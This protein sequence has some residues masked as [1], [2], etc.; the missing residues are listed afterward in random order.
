MAFSPFASQELGGDPHNHQLEREGQKWGGA[1]ELGCHVVG[2]CP[3]K[4]YHDY[5]PAIQSIEC[6][7]LLEGLS[8]VWLLRYERKKIILAVAKFLSALAALR[9][10]VQN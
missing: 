3:C 10:V 8:S 6:F 4:P 7:I 1:G 9:A 2:L 5:S